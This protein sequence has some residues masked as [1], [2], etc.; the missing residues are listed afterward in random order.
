MKSL[1]YPNGVHSK[2]DFISSLNRDDIAY[3]AISC[4]QDEKTVKALEMLE[5]KL[6][7]AIK[8]SESAILAAIK[9][10][11]KDASA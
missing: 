1:K 10:S 2:R 8:A 7:D 11:C 6:L 9:A 5:V 3:R 4:L